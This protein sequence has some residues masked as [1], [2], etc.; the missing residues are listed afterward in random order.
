IMDRGRIAQVG[1]YQHIY[2]QPTN[3][4][5]AGFL[6]RN[7]GT[8]PINFV[9]A[10]HVLDGESAGNVRVGVR[11][12]DVLISAEASS[13][14]IEGIIREK[15][16]LPMNSGTI[17]HVQVG[18]HEIHA[19]TTGIERLR[20]GDRVW[21]AFRRYHVFDRESGERLRSPPLTV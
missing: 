20:A 11:P 8:P 18:D 2:D 9:D 10:R 17:V 16:D 7:T 13:G 5:V 1:T 12:E 6:N 19:Q 14:S 4:F 3:V 21:L 15:L